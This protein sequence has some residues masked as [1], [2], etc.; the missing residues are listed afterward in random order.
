MVEEDL[1]RR[2]YEEKRV[3]HIDLHN[4][5]FSDAILKGALSSK[6]NKNDIY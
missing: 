6:K 2:T 4:V 5:T 3:Q 1:E